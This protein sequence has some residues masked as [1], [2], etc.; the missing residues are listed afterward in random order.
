V[1]VISFVLELE[2]GG[3]THEALVRWTITSWPSRRGGTTSIRI[4]LHEY[5]EVSAIV[6]LLKDCLE[7]EHQ[8]N[9]Y[10]KKLIIR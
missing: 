8:R 1:E 3:P 5:F 9:S 4:V 10:K 7:T 2:F 6:D